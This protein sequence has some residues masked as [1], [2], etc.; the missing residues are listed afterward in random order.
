M[1]AES[2]LIVRLRREIS[3][4]LNPGMVFVI[5][6]TTFEFIYKLPVGIKCFLKNI[7]KRMIMVWV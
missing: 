4:A 3:I 5:K 1:L 7:S 6:L 2:Q